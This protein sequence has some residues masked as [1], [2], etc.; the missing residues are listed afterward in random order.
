MKNTTKRWAMYAGLLG[1]STLC[2]GST[3]KGDIIVSYEALNTPDG[4]PASDLFP[5]LAA[6]DLTRGSGLGV[7][8]GSTF[9]SSGWTDE[10]TDYLEWGWTAST[11]VNLTDLDIRYD[12]S[13]SGPSSLD[14]QLAINGGAF[15]SVFFDSSVSDAGEDNLDIDLSSF[16]DVTSAVFRLFGFNASSAGGTF[17][18]EPISGLDPARGIVVNGVAAVPEPSALVL[19]SIAC[20]GLA[21]GRRKRGRRSRTSLATLGLRP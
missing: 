7:G 15:S 2:S 1:I 3:A 6:L 13:S 14:I 20:V 19:T 18:I 5:G 4:A 9:N 10:A 11:P 16:T 8:T 17:D 21:W 12:R